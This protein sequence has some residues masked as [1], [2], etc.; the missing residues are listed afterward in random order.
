MNVSGISQTP[1]GDKAHSHLSAF[2]CPPYEPSDEI[3]RS[4]ANFGRR[5]CGFVP[6]LRLCAPAVNLILR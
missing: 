2:T 4:Q 6:S 1:V 3:S 5:V